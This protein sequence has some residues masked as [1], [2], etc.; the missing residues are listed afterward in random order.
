MIV[1]VTELTAQH[2]EVGEQNVHLFVENPNLKEP[3]LTEVLEMDLDTIDKE[4]PIS[5]KAADF[6]AE[7]PD[8]TKADVED[9]L[10]P[11]KGP[12]DLIKEAMDKATNAV[13]VPGECRNYCGYMADLLNAAGYEAEVLASGGPTGTRHAIVKVTIH[14]PDGSSTIYYADPTNGIAFM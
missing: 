3:V 7:Y 2:K 5:K 6:V 14:N 13:G 1:I 4:G 10:S 12:K 8:P 11:P 9:L